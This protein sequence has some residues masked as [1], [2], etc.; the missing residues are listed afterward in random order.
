MDS[1]A[2]RVEPG[3]KFNLTKI[4]TR[5]S[6]D[7][8]R[9]TAEARLEE[10]TNELSDLQ[11]MLYA[12]DTHSVLVV[13]QGMDTSGKDGT[14]RKVFSKIEILGARMADFKTPSSLELSHDFLWRV[15]YRVPQRGDLV[16][17]NRS[18]YEDVL[19][20][21]VRNLVPEAVWSKRYRHI[22]DFERLLA[23]HNTIILKFFLHISKDEQK[24]RLLEREQDITKA[25]KL[26]PGDWYERPYWDDYMQAYEDALRECSTEYAPWYVIP[27]DRKW[28]RNIAVAET[29]VAT[30]RAYVPQWAQVLEKMSA[31]RLAELEQITERNV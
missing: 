24:K 20:A 4:E 2:I 23:D 17:F 3:K 18:H 5:Y 8:D 10:L 12:A 14:I 29:L 27:A 22:N 11:E 13:L 16:V 25:W 28:F 31:E 21:R 1:L 7:L 30:L 19:I 9:A 6:G 26:S 15:H